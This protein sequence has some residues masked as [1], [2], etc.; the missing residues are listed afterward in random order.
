MVGQSSLIDGR[1]VKVK[2]CG[3]KDL[4]TAL[5]AINAGADALGFVFAPS[6][7]RISSQEAK[8]LI[9]ALPSFIIKVGVFVDAPIKMVDDIAC[10]CNLDVIQLHGHESPAYCSFLRRKHQVI[11]AFQVKKGVSEALIN[12]YPVDA[13]LLDTY[14]PERAGGTGK[15][16][17]WTVARNLKLNHP[18]ILAGGLTPKNVSEAIVLVNPYAVDVSSGVETNGKKDITKIHEFIV[19]A[20]GEKHVSK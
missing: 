4:K 8:T 3:I 6:S 9:Q 2:I 14:I 12:N 1:M 13:V 20:K 18:L 16:F 10:Y 15:S 11:K 19:K 7:R 17:D 5:A